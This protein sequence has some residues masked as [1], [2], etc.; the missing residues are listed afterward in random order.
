MVGINLVD[1]VSS[2]FTRLVSVLVQYM[3]YD[4]NTHDTRVNSSFLWRAKLL[5]SIHNL[6]DALRVFDLCSA[7]SYCPPHTVITKYF[8]TKGV[9]LEDFSTRLAF[10]F[11]LV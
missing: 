8:T 5:H 2:V 4:L 11:R 6:L 10:P 3:A 9:V 1:N 7:H